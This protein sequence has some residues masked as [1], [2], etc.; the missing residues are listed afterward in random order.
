MLVTFILKNSK[1]VQNLSSEAVGLL[2]KRLSW[3]DLM[4]LKQLCQ[5]IYIINEKL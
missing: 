3:Y 5:F 1:N 4:R 2:L